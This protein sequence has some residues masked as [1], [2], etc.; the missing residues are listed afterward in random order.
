MFEGLKKHWTVFSQAW[1][2]ENEQQASPTV[3]GDVEFL[4]AALEVMERPASPAGRGLVWLM[5]AFFTVTLVWSWFGHVDVVA[6]ATGKTVPV[7]RVKHI[8]AA[9]MGVVRAIHVRDGQSV[10]AGDPLIDLDPSFSDADQAQAIQN[11]KSAEAA[12]ARAAALFRFATGEQA[13]TTGVP[14]RL[15]RLHQSLVDSQIDEFEA[16]Q[17]SFARQREEAEAERIATLKELNKLQETLPL[18][19]EQLAARTEL[20]EQ[21]LSPRLLY[22]ELKERHVAHLKNIDIQ[23]QRLVQ[24]DA[25]INQAVS[26]QEQHRQEFRRGVMEQLTQAD[27]EVKLRRAELDKAQRRGAL[28]TLSSPVFGQ[29]Q[30]LAVHTLGGVV[31]PAEPLMVIVP[32]DGR[33]HVEALVLNRDI[34]SVVIGDPVEIKLEAFPFTKFGVLHGRLENISLDAIQDENLGPVYAAT[35]S[36]EEHHIEVNGTKQALSAGMSVTAEIKTGERRL[37]EFLLAP[38]LRYR[39]ESLRER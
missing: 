17:S 8:Q 15:D 34:G 18:L 38:L 3:R 35:V 4:P 32:G 11:L 2:H 12:L 10:Q 28:Q 13:Q 23:Q 19:E 22:L 6:T 33:L 30:Q 16:A 7:E 1:R 37:I 27:D 20:M 9:E 26:R 21:G 39:D 24:V 5:V 14:S 25:S 29:V 31:Q 36:L